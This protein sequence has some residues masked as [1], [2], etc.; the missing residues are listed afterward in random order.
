MSG[1]CGMAPFSLQLISRIEIY[2]S[3]LAELCDV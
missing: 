1:N 2:F 3:L